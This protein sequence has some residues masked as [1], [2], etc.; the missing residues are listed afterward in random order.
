MPGGT[1]TAGSDRTP[2][3]PANGNGPLRTSEWG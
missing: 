3:V 2:K 1:G